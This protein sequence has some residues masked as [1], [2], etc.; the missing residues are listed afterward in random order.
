MWFYSPRKKFARRAQRENRLCFFWEYEKLRREPQT[1]VDWQGLVFFLVAK[2]SSLL[3]VPYSGRDCKRVSKFIARWNDAL[4]TF[5][6]DHI[7]DLFK[8]LETVVSLPLFKQLL[9]GS[10]HVFPRPGE[11]RAAVAFA[12]ESS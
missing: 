1:F 6:E 11:T 4:L 12:T 3:E 5:G 8:E 2:A 7:V 9:E 10:R